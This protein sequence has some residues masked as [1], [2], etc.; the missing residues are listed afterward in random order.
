MLDETTS[1]HVTNLILNFLLL[2]MGIAVRAHVYGV[3][4]LE[5]RDV[6]VG[7]ARRGNYFGLGEEVVYFLTKGSSQEAWTVSRG[8]R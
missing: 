4:T 2:E 6:V 3:G 7:G 5:E 1:K 8:L